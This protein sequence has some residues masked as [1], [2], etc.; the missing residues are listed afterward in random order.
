MLEQGYI[1]KQVHPTDPLAIFNYTEK[2]TFDR[3]WNDATRMCRGLIVNTETDEVA[4]RPFPKF[5]N[6][7]ESD[8]PSIEAD[9]PVWV[10]DKMD[11]SLGIRYWQ[12]NS[13]RWA[14]ATRGSFTSEQAIEGTRML[15]EYYDGKH[16]APD[17]HE[18]RFTQ[19]F[20]IIYPENRIVLDY[21]GRRELV[22]L[23]GVE[24]ST[25]M[26]YPVTSLTEDMWHADG[27]S[28]PKVFEAETY[29]EALALKP[30]DNAEGIVVVTRTDNCQR[31]VKIKQSDYIALH[32][33][34]T[35]LNDRVIWER[36]RA[37][38]APD[39]IKYGVPEEFWYYIDCTAA[40]LTEEHDDCI[41]AAY[42]LY[43]A[44]NKVLNARH[45][46]YMWERKHFAAEAVK[47]SVRDL[48]FLLF[49]N[50]NISDVVWRK[51]KPEAAN[52]PFQMNS[53]AD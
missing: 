29:G 8:A 32:K 16:Y 5:F 30:R 46:M 42:Q 21:K 43:E 19:L 41:R 38:D 33:T 20:E 6:W 17:W 27:F 18:A 39:K 31:M 1:R 23:G 35:G 25:G 44:I 13:K 50:K 28:T 26:I 14:I 9:V 12:P 10:T 2:A 7:N 15:D 36:L 37:G 52:G 48:L 45:G 22:A 4:A 24:I 11:G 40:E 51:L 53:D 34:I 47:Y 3:V 49:D